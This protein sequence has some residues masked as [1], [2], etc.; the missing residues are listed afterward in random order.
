MPRPDASAKLAATKPKAGPPPMLIAAVVITVVVVVAAA[1]F[2]WTKPWAKQEAQGPTHSIAQGNGIV[3]YAGKAKAGVPTV[4]IYE[5]FQCPFCK[6][7]EDANGSQIQQLASSGD[8][9]LVY[10]VMDFLDQNMNNDS[11]ERAANA[12]FCAAD[13]GAFEA[14]HETVFAH[15]PEQEGAGYTNAQLKQFG[16]MAGITGSKATTF[17]SCVDK[18]T[19]K[20]YVDDTQTRSNNDGINGTPTIKINGKKLDDTTVQNLTTQP[21]TF[22]T[23]LKQQTGK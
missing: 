22:S 8:I 9:K 19:Y 12:A 7:L 14:Y 23:V 2:L 17:N 4:D 11:S 13:E 1:A 5:D 20:Q 16:T 18:L 21:N 10:H 6:H 3:A 15:Q